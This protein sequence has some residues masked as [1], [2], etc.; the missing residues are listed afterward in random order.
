M[1]YPTPSRVDIPLCLEFSARVQGEKKNQF[2]P[3]ALR[4]L[5]NILAWKTKGTGNF[6]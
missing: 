5:Q 1:F 2:P 4:K 6:F 3:K